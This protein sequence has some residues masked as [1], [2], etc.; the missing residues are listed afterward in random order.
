MLYYASLS[1]VMSYG[2]IVI[3]LR[4]Y[5]LERREENMSAGVM[6]KA[7]FAIG[8]IV[9]IGALTADYTGLS[10]HGGLGKV[11]KRWLAGGF[12]MCLA[13]FILHKRSKKGA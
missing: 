9:L 1:C 12:I 3:E 11:E 2:Y 10:H 8:V 5:K 4:Y 13:G 7:L 6:G